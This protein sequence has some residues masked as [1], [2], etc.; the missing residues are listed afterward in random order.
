MRMN[1]SARSTPVFT[2][3]GAPGARHLSAEQQLRRTVMSCLL[4]EKEFYEDGKSIA[5]RIVES[6]EKVAPA[7][8]A[9]IAIEAREVFN[10]R[11]VPLLLLDV[12]SKTGAERQSFRKRSRG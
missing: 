6:A 1:V 5:D 10:L 3:E 9:G 8:L 2:H 12:L 7:V 11:H 4:W